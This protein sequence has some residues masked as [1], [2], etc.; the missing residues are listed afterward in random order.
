VDGLVF[1]K[2][3]CTPGS[4]FALWTRVVYLTGV[5]YVN[6]ESGKIGL[7]SKDQGMS[8]RLLYVRSESVE[9]ILDEIK[10]VSQASLTLLSITLSPPHSI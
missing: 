5:E 3:E 1:R 9:Q 4:Y 8:P 6:D 10:H 2:T 7:T